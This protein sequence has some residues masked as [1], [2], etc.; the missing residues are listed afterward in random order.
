MLGRFALYSSTARDRNLIMRLTSWKIS[1]RNYT[2]RTIW[3]RFDGISSSGYQRLETN[4][5]SE[6]RSALTHRRMSKI[7]S[8]YRFCH[9][10]GGTW[11]TV[12]MIA[13]V[14][15]PRAVR[16]VTCS[17]RWYESCIQKFFRASLC[18][19]HVHPRLDHHTCACCFHTYLFLYS[20]IYTLA[21][22]YVTS[23]VRIYVTHT[24]KLHTRI[25]IYS[26]VSRVTPRLV[27]LRPCSH[28]KFSPRISR[29][30]NNLH[31]YLR[32][33]PCLHAG[34]YERHV[35]A[36]YTATSPAHFHV[37]FPSCSHAHDRAFTFMPVSAITPIRLHTRKATLMPAAKASASHGAPNL[38]SPSSHTLGRHDASV[39]EGGS[40]SDT[41]KQGK[42]PWAVGRTRT[43]YG[44]C[45]Q[46]SN[47]KRYSARACNPRTTLLVP[48]SDATAHG[49][50]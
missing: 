25:R 6:S 15:N 39:L 33:Y 36:A 14:S 20:L 50:V 9:F 13:H 29:E 22:L 2:N 19:S 35:R 10:S 40:R 16:P 4:L 32:F 45:K 26:N 7:E 42:A 12:W 17:V 47:E 41:E 23:L 48:T 24:F 31:T 8:A 43:W 28:L 44:P 30:K 37:N 21:N 11:N 46:R 38:L 18:E 3:A 34:T 1:K 27:H 49:Y 5:L